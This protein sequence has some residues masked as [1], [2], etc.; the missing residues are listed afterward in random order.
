MQSEAPRLHPSV[1]LTVD[2]VAIKPSLALD[3]D[4]ELK[5]AGVN[6]VIENACITKVTTGTLTSTI[7]LTCQ[8][9]ELT[10]RS[11]SIDLPGALDLP[12]GG[13][14]LSGVPR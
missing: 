14:D 2:G 10:N 11:T 8:D 5:L 12:H 1:R 9:V 3:V 4:I 7:R 6:I 13:V